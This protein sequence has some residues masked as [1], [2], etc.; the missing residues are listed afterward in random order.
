MKGNK[1]NCKTQP[2]YSF[3]CEYVGCLKLVKLR[4]EIKFKEIKIKRIINNKIPL[5]KHLQFDINYLV[6]IIVIIILIQFYKN[7]QKTKN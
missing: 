4:E 5:I 2:H 3:V 6:F 7:I 1:R